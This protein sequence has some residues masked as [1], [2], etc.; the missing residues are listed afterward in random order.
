MKKNALRILALIFAIAV[1]AT[2]FT[3]C[4][5]GMMGQTPKVMDDEKDAKPFE[6][7][8]IGFVRTADPLVNI[9]TP[10]GYFCYEDNEMRILTPNSKTVD[11]V[12]DGIKE[13][14]VAVYDGKKNAD[15]SNFAK[16]EDYSFSINE[17]NGYLYLNSKVLGDVEIEVECENGTALMGETA[18]LLEV[19]PRT[20]SLFDI[21]IGVIS[22]Y[23]IYSAIVGKGKLFQNEF[24]KEGME[25]KHR[26]IVRITA[27]VIG[28]AIAFLDKYGNYR[29]ATM[30]IFGVI[31]VAFI[32]ASILL[33]SCTDLEAKRK[34]ANDRYAGV[35]VKSP[36]AA[37]IFDAEEPTVDDIKN[38]KQTLN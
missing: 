1:A 27:L 20:G 18:L 37:F 32:V 35:S 5:G 38:N 22:L 30:I 29:L 3:G 17:K 24:I 21:I 33:R 4:L 14:S 34:A 28:I 36:A 7:R 12:P 6:E 15:G 13:L 11:G 2:V 23:L 25:A 19:K 10:I 8:K 9:N 31:L 16:N 26:S